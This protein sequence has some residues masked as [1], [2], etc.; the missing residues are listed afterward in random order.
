MPHRGLG[1][2]ALGVVATGL[3][4]CSSG[5][6]AG[7]ADIP[8]GG[9]TRLAAPA[10]VGQALGPAGSP[11]GGG[12][13][14]EPASERS[15]PVG[16]RGVVAL[17]AAWLTQAP[18]VA[19]QG[20]AVADGASVI[21]QNG[22]SVIGQNGAALIG[23]GGVRLAGVRV[24]LRTAG[25][26]VVRSLAGDPVEAVTDAVGAFELPPHTVNGQAVIEVEA[27]ALGGALLALAP[28]EGAEA[29]RVDVYTTL[30][31]R[32]ILD[33]LVQQQQALLDRLPGPL[34]EAAGERLAGAL[35]PDRLGGLTPRSLEPEALRETVRTAVLASSVVSDAFEELSAALVVAGTQRDDDGQ[36]AAGAAL[37]EVTALLPDGAEAWLFSQSRHVVWRLDAGGKLHVAVASGAWGYPDEAA[38]PPQHPTVSGMVRWQGGLALA[39]TLRHRVVHLAGGAVRVL[40][41]TGLAGRSTLPA[42]AAAAALAFPTGVAELPDGRLAIAEAG[43]DRVLALAAD[44]RLE[45]LLGEDAREDTP[46]SPTDMLRTP[47]GLAADATSLWVVDHGHDRLRRLRLADGL[48]EDVALGRA[49]RGPLAV[50]LSAAGPLVMEHRHG[51]LTAFDAGQAGARLTLPGEEPLGWLGALG[52]DGRRGLV[53]DG[54]GRV[55]AFEG[56]LEGPRVVAGDPQVRSWERFTGA[57]RLAVAPDGRVFVADPS[58]RRLYVIESDGATRVAAGSGAE[59]FLQGGQYAWRTPLGPL[60]AV[61]A[62][63]RGGVALA[64]S[65]AF[66]C[67]KW[68]DGDGHLTTLVGDGRPGHG[69]AGEGPA[70]GVSLGSPAELA[71]MPDGRLVFYDADLDR[72]LVLEADG[73]VRAMAAW[74]DLRAPR[75]LRAAGG[76]AFVCIEGG[77][78]R[79]IRLV[80]TAREVLATRAEIEPLMAFGALTAALLGPDGSLWLG[81]ERRVLR[82]DPGGPLRVFAGPGGEVLS[83]P[84]G[85]ETLRDVRDLA[86]DAEGRLLIL[87]L[88]QLKRVVLPSRGR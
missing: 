47:L 51:G 49:L 33:G 69:S 5:P 63:P 59:G 32:E 88:D 67:L 10:S 34:V 87:E 40:A 17:P 82:K 66:P 65:G 19:R 26:A 38:A 15:R 74:A 72:M 41:G 39:D 12:R 71:Y 56:R 43:Q 81:G 68:L 28:R 52:W 31:M 11:A 50:G 62:S 8:P 55:V 27:P 79:V 21:G 53:V 20:L 25:G 80:G 78:E 23:D 22:A 61:V 1:R 4:A 54:Q 48:V 18:V 6:F 7:A 77:G 86:F 58:A 46:A 35:P 84:G 70:T 45:V 42:R 73:H 29:V 60:T 75:A 85:D 37:G 16:V 57:T 36:A 30:V 3:T 13:D 2:A 44:G 83:Q 64:V 76:G 9:R 24:R 14:A